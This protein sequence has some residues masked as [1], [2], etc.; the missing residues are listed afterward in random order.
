M[1]MKSDKINLFII[2]MMEETRKYISAAIWRI[3]KK[4]RSKNLI[5]ESVRV[6]MQQNKK[7]KSAR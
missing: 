6:L 3:R 2:S 7:I 4:I 5:V 1:N